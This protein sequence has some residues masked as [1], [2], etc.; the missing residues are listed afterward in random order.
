MDIEALVI[1]A[2]FWLVPSPAP[3]W[4]ETQDQY[5]E[6]VKTIAV[7][8][9][10]TTNDPEMA[11]AIVTQ[12]RYE[13]HFSKNVHSGKKL[14]DGGRAICL[15]QHHINWRTKSE[16][17]ALA[18]LD[19]ESTLRCASATRDA[20]QAGRRFCR[21]N[22]GKRIDWRHIFSYYSTGRSCLECRY[23]R[24]ERLLNRIKKK[25]LEGKNGK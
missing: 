1:A 22:H 24:R 5:N 19:L 11:L 2:V 9:S 3:H 25:F 23:M 8:T 21:V 4:R 16:W 15:G 13:S 20:L 18:G 6:R 17:Q 7:A 10:E 14:G 12:F